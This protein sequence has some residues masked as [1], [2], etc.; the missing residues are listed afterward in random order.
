MI[1]TDKTTNAAAAAADAMLLSIQ[2]DGA[3][4]LVVEYRGEWWG[5]LSSHA[6]PVE[7]VECANMLNASKPIRRG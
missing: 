6:T 5:V 7:L 1:R 4:V 3:L 2:N